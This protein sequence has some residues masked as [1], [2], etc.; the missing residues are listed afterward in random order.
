MLTSISEVD[1]ERTKTL[2]A[3]ILLVVKLLES[4]V[5]NNSDITELLT[6]LTVTPI[7]AATAPKD[8]IRVVL[9]EAIISSE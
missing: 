2:F 7:E 3:E 8:P 5:D 1:L 4:S 6:T 9:S